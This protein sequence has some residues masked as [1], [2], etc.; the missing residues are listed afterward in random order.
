M[1][2]DL[3]CTGCGVCAS[4]CPAG[5]I[6]MRDGGEGF[7]YPA[8]DEQKCLH[9]DVCTRC[10][11]LNSDRRNGPIAAY[12]AINKCGCDIE[13]SSSGGVFSALARTVL[14]E[15]GLVCGCALRGHAAEHIIISGEEELYLLQGSKYT[16]SSIAAILPQLREALD[17]GRTILF[18]GTGCQTAAVK[19]Y[20]GGEPENLILAEILCH[21]VPSG[22]LFG[23]M[24][25]FIEKEQGEKITDFR[26]RCK[27]N[28]SWESSYK[29]RSTFA[30]GAVRYTPFCDSAYCSYFLKG[31]IF[32]ESCYNCRYTGMSRSGDLT[33]GD[34]WGVENFHS[35]IN[36]TKGASL[37]L[38]GSEKGEKLLRK[39][40]EMLR[41]IPTDAANAA[42]FNHSLTAPCAR[43][44][45]RSGIYKEIISL[46]YEKWSRQYSRSAFRCKERIKFIAKKILPPRIRQKIRFMRAAG[47]THTR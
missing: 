26:F 12:A 14:S 21:G 24:L 6:E 18:S 5:C 11:H 37:V 43:P 15:G 22:R 34:Y 25:D 41:L 19:A 27:D 7:C 42:I 40:S 32:R 28:G 3:N 17:A 47:R 29:C 38:I 8:V 16:E 9:C 10:C 44:E 39:C 46:G 2:T 23:E 36:P 30:S 45:C 13:K 31:Y 1:T 20:L 35:E 33:L 4:L